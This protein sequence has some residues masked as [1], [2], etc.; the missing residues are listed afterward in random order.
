MFEVRNLHSFSYYLIYLQKVPIF[1]VCGFNNAIV[2]GKMEDANLIAVETYIRD[3]LPKILENFAKEERELSSRE[4]SFFFSSK[5]VQ[6]MADFKFMEGEKILIKEIVNHVKVKHSSPMLPSVVD[7]S[8]K[9][10]KNDMK[11]IVETSIGLIFG[12]NLEESHNKHRSTKEKL[13]SLVAK[14]TESYKVKYPSIVETHENRINLD[15]SS[16]DNIKA[17]VTCAFCK[18]DVNIS[19]KKSGTWI[20]SNLK[21]HM[22]SYCVVIKME[23]EE[24]KTI[25]NEIISSTEA[26]NQ[27][28]TFIIQQNLFKTQ[29]TLQSIKMCNTSIQNKEQ[30]DDCECEINSKGSKV[31]AQIKVAKIPPDGNCLIG[32]AVHQ[33][34]HVKIA[35]DDY[36]KHVIQLRKNIVDHIRNNLE[37]Y[38]RYL[39]GHAKY[40]NKEKKGTI[41]TCH[42]FLDSYL[43]KEGFW[44]GTESMKAIS[45]LLKTNIVVFTERGEVYFAHPFDSSFKNVMMFAYRF[46]SQKNSNEQIVNAERDHYDSVIRLDDSVIEMCSFYL[47]LRCAKSRSL[48]LTDDVITLD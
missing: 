7:A 17:E 38:E 16:S 4:K 21:R 41:E 19:C 11:G 27:D 47:L 23:Q 46:F 34:H 18:K 3:D 20:L 31:I 40:A 12:E 9:N 39:A 2:I 6:N 10:V 1:S 13:E 44:C 29:L 35:S 24:T 22:D 14:M 48:N 30:E 37:Q 5:Y 36:K 42:E 26:N 8:G 33:F 32:A 25:Q 43:S 15:T 45:E 28:D